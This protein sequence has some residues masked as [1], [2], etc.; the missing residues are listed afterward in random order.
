[1]QETA[2]RPPIQVDLPLYK[3][4]LKG[5]RIEKD[6]IYQQMTALPSA[7]KEPRNQVLQRHAGILKD[8]L[9]A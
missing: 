6:R 2:L 9:F 4:Y 7:E 8:V 5:E 3:F 1:M